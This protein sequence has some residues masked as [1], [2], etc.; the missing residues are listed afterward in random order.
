MLALIVTVLQRV[1]LPCVNVTFPV[2]RTFVDELEGGVTVAVRVTCWFT[3]GEVGED[4]N[5]V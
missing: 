5:M 1:V 2:G 4:V 3:A